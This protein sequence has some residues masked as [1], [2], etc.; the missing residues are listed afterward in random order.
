MDASP[1]A[2]GNGFDAA[3]KALEDLDTTVAPPREAAPAIVVAPAIEPVSALA[4]SDAEDPGEPAAILAIAVPEIVELPN[5][6]AGPVAAPQ[7][8]AAAAPVPVQAEAAPAAPVHVVAAPTRGTFTKVAI[9]LGL[10]SSAVSAAGLI[11]AERTIMS[12]QLVVA[13]AR[14]RQRQLEHANKLIDDLERVRDKQVELLR[15]QQAQLSAAPVSSAELQHRME[16]LQAGLL[17][18]DPLNEV[19]VAI[20]EGQAGTNARFSEFGMKIERLEAAMGRGGD[21]H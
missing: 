11:V 6:P 16:T 15:A 8:I 14:E 5:Q 20:R 1:S 19:V 21:G 3:L 10:V 4:F 12:A 9:G 2:S 13:D 18:R 17:A 7:P